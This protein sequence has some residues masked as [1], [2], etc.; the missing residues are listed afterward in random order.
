MLIKCW[1]SLAF[2]TR[3][4]SGGISDNTIICPV[5]SLIAQ[6]RSP[7][8]AAEVSVNTSGSIKGIRQFL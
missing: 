6:N 3:L 1:L 7:A 2:I 8:S 5:T 4:L